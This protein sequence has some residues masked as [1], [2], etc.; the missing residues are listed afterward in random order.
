M[1]FDKDKV[2]KFY[3]ESGKK[4][5]LK[6][7]SLDLPYIKG[8][9]YYGGKEDGPCHIKYSRIEAIKEIIK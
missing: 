4:F 7:V 2:Y 8:E 9:P 1:R 5:T 3:L 6:N